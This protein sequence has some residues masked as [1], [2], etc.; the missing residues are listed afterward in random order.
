MT[1]GA[2]VPW[3]TVA[4]EDVK[5]DT[6]PPDMDAPEEPTAAL[7][8][9]DDHAA[10]EAAPVHQQPKSLREIATGLWNQKPGVRE[11]RSGAN[12]RALGAKEVVNGLDRKELMIGTG[13]MLVDL[14]LTVIVFFYWRHSTDLKARHYAP[15]FLVAGLV[16]VAIMAFGSALR[17]RALLGFAAFIVGME[18]ISFGLVYGILYLFF[19]GW[20][21]IRVMR[22]QRQDQARGKFTGTIDTGSKSKRGPSTPQTPTASKRYT[23]PRRAKTAAKKR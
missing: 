17:R 8:A 15:D 3:C 1:T 22:K 6:P 9:P 20:L 12:D 14:A 19:G 7:P 2:Q 13:L 10:T 5:A 4:T 21:I 11:S 16:G 23:P 18:L